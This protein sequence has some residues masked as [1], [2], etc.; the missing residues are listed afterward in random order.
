MRV[1]IFLTILSLFLVSFA[2]SQNGFIRGSVFDAKNGEYLVGV[3]VFAEG[4]T[5]GS[6]TDLD[7]KFNLSIAPGTYDIRISYV[8]YNTKKIEGVEV[9]AGEVTMLDEISLE[10]ATIGLDEVIVTAQAVRNTETAL[11]TMKSKSANL[12]DGISATNLRR[13][14]D[15]DAAASMKRIT[16]VSVEGGKYVYVRGLGD[17][18]TKTVLNGM[19]IP[20]LDPDRNS[21]QMDIFPTNVIDNL[22]VHK[23]FSAELPADFTGGV[24]DIVTKDFPGEKNG[25]ISVSGGYNPDMHFNDDFITQQGGD[26]DWLG[27][28]DGTRDIPATSNVPFFTEALAGP[29]SENGQRFK[30]ILRGFN[31][32]MA[33]V[34]ES[35]FMDYGFKASFGNQ[36]KKNET[37]YGYN[38]VASYQKETDFYQDAQFSRYGLGSPDVY[39]MERRE[40]QIGDYGVENVFLTGMA[41]FAIKKLNSKYKFNLLHLQNG[42]SEAGI[43]DYSGSDQGS[44]FDAYQHNIDYSQRSLTN[45]L[46]EGKHNFDESKWEINWKLSP[47]ISKIDDPDVRFVRYEK[48]D[49]GTFGI[50]TEVGFP[51]R[52]WRE[53]DEINLSGK[54]DVERKFTFMGDDANVKFGVA[55]TFKERD[56]SIRSFALN[57]RNIPLTGNPDELFFEENLWPYNG[58]INRGTTYEARFVPTNPNSFNS[59]ANVSAGYISTELTL[60]EKLKSVVG[61]R[62]EN[63][64]QFYSGINQSTNIDF[65]NE[66]LIND[67]D[68]F[69]TINLIYNVSDKQNIR[70]SGSKTIAR[71]SFKEMS[72]AEIYDPITGRTFIGGMFKDDDPVNDITY[73]D[74]NLES[75]DIYNA[76]LRWELFMEQGQMISFSGFYKKFN[77]PIEMVQYATQTGAFQ[78]RNVGD[79]TVFGG[80]TEIRLSLSPL[81]ESLKN[82]KM[83]F[84]YTITKSQIKMSETEY[85]D[86]VKNAREGEEIDEYRDMA[87]QAPYIVNAGLQYTGGENGFA[88]NFEAGLYY[89]V[90]GETLYYVGIVDRPDI[91]TAPFHSLNFTAS[92]D[93]GKDNRFS[94][95][96]KAKNILNDKEESIF[97]SYNA[98]DQP[99]EYLYKGTSFSLSLKYD[100]F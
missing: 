91:Y 5:T 26:T 10:Q 37:T 39:E 75:S 38:V 100:L 29:D 73:W 34:N 7:G 59:K 51:E 50:G 64:I 25:N 6:I 52:I 82:V 80:E 15:S 12:V 92:K 87:G 14:G 24:V 16:G 97:K 46:L 71:P 54:I 43:F 67:L 93:F 88:Q 58:D 85:N 31:P 90:Q 4:T 53:L 63:Y 94:L 44:A 86:R 76:D 66:E 21:I 3:T 8:S 11:L 62:V 22:I 98:E 20:G 28:D 13:I 77:N 32:N 35:N 36:I 45:L 30:E 56:F 57:I 49:G 84:N 83:I 23:S 72:F 1:K 65:D 55:N 78:P 40:Y 2:N 47:T 60:S 95:G 99:F 96:L 18:Y 81:S 48:Q 74:G 61:L 42:E 41:S 79:G 19:E 27:F 68:F 70:L 89:N 17:R 33:A 69:P 9:K